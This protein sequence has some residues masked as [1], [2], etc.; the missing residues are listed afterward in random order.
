MFTVLW[1]VPLATM[2]ETKPLYP[3]SDMWV[4]NDSDF[5][6]RFPLLLKPACPGL[7]QIVTASQLEIWASLCD[8]AGIVLKYQKVLNC[9]NTRDFEHK[10]LMNITTCSGLLCIEGRELTEEE[11][12][13]VKDSYLVM[14]IDEPEPVRDGRH[15]SG[16]KFL[17]LVFIIDFLYCIL[18]LLSNEKKIVKNGRQLTE[19]FSLE[20][21]LSPARV[22]LCLTTESL[23]KAFKWMTT[24]PLASCRI[25][26][27]KPNVLPSVP[28]VMNAGASKVFPLSRDGNA[29]PI[30]ELIPW[31]IFTNDLGRRYQSIFQGKASVATV[32]FAYAIQMSKKGCPDVPQT[33]VEDSLEDHMNTLTKCCEPPQPNLWDEVVASGG[34]PVFD[35]GVLFAHN[36]EEFYGFLDDA[37]DYLLPSIFAGCQ[38]TRQD[39]RECRVPSTKA[40]YEN[41][42][43]RGG[44]REYIREILFEEPLL[45]DFFNDYLYKMYEV[46]QGRAKELRT[47]FLTPDQDIMDLLWEKSFKR[48]LPVEERRCHSSTVAI[49]E[50]LKVRVITKSEAIPQYLSIPWQKGLHGALRKCFIF[51]ALDHPITGY[52]IE[53]LRQKSPD[54]GIWVSG[55]Y[56]GATDGLDM[57]VTERVAR[58]ALLQLSPWLSSE[59]LQVL[60]DNLVGQLIDYP[61]LN[62]EDVP[63]RNGQLMGSILSFPILCLINYLTYFFST[64]LLRTDFFEWR[65]LGKPERTDRQIR[66]LSRRLQREPVFINGDDILFRA[67]EVEYDRWE[68]NLRFFG[69]KL[70]AGKNLCSDRFMMINS[71][72][73]FRKRV[74]LP[75]DDTFLSLTYPNLGLLKG[76]SKVGGGDTIDMK[77]LWTIHNDILPGFSDEKVFH[78]HYEIWN[79]RILDIYSA[80]GKRNYY[81]PRMLGMCGLY[82]SEVE[83]TEPQRC[84][85]TGLLQQLQTYGDHQWKPPGLRLK[86]AEILGVDDTWND[87]V[88]KQPHLGFYVPLR[89]P[90]PPG[91]TSAEISRSLRNHV[92]EGY[93]DPD[94]KLVY[95]QGSG[96]PKVYIRPESA[97]GARTLLSFTEGFRFCRV[98]L[99]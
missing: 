26:A 87:C 70:S 73:Y 60:L 17:R 63:Q 43:V 56:K 16:E 35:T 8:F 27:G 4:G 22:L 13:I 89:C 28:L 72:A 93:L 97:Y 59:E 21:L 30:S 48:H 92:L 24:Y 2:K 12:R 54:S 10:W 18:F 78:S 66:R 11:I 58:K 25:L 74:G 49:L 55:D 68:S 32:K 20:K 50:P 46:R 14:V 85:A 53:V 3:R 38:V 52:D 51:S 81:G 94:N 82:S 99:G 86:T 95:H 79:R 61:L 19:L 42:G 77:P 98:S 45:A 15:H 37:L 29:Y 91:F 71:Q 40:C 88:N 80:S 9:Y 69:F 65:S 33:F 31:Y 76:R 1:M 47:H 62:E 41:Q 44:S 84:W 64:S 36:K 83:M 23:V 96:Y 7:G 75:V 57:N 6:T 67:S 34:D 90:D 39:T 5:L